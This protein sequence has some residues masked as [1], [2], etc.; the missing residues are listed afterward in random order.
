MDTYPL[1][2]SLKA[3]LEGEQ[4]GYRSVCSFFGGEVKQIRER[5]LQPGGTPL[6]AGM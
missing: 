3:Y 2:F 1:L 5:D 6:Q 4:K